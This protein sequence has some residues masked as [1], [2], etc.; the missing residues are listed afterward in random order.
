MD[1]FYI[2]GGNQLNGECSISCAKNAMLP[3][4]AG[5]ILCD[6]D[7][8]IKNCAMYSDVNYMLKI[9]EQVGCYVKII[10]KDIYINPIDADKYSIDE[11]YMKKIRSS[12]FM[13]GPLLARFRKAKVS[14]PGGCNIG[15][16]PIDL[17]LKG[18][19]DLNVRIIERHGYIYCDGSSMQAGDVHLDFPS[20]GATENII[21]ASIFLKG[22]TTI[23]NAAK[24]PEIADLCNFLNSMGAKIMGGGTSVIRVEGVDSLHTTSYT[25]ISDRIIAGTYMIAVGMTGGKVLLR[26]A[27]AEHNLSLINK[28]KQ[29]GIS[30]AAKNN[31]VHIKSNSKPRSVNFETMPYPGFPTDLQ[32]QALTLQT[33]SKGTSVISENL[34]ETRYKICTELIK[35]GADIK[36]KD[37]T[38]IIKGVPKLYGAS[39]TATDLRGGAGLVLAGL[40]AEGYTTIFDVYHIDRGYYCIENDL[41]ALGA[42]IVRKN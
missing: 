40:K 22:T 14:Y 39:V 33:I 38:A 6:D 29:S 4:L 21:M 32:S 13:L 15:L 37:K 28:L 23:Q 11:E 42:C 5:S 27:N 1:S 34:F 8:L 17:H 19:R 3:I 9:L 36:L 10:D 30:V 31:C 24:E 7:L 35:M 25:P 16:R 2:E 26:N 12:I 20:V 41:T 18:L